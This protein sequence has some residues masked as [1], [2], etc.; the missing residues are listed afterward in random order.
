[1]TSGPA[2]R[3][4]KGWGARPPPRPP[5][6]PPPQPPHPIGEQ[7]RVADH[8]RPGS[9]PQRRDH[10][11]R[12]EIAH[13]H[14]LDLAPAKHRQPAQHERRAEPARHEQRRP[15]DAQQRALP[16]AGPA[17]RHAPL[18]VPRR[19]SSSGPTRVI[20]PAPKGNTTSP[21]STL[22]ATR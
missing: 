12:R 20:S 7:P 18:S 13:A 21:A 4:T 2:S 16:P 14:E 8:A 3:P 10:G 17:S 9:E 11:I 5:P 22:S 1:M 15:R 19:A 6:G